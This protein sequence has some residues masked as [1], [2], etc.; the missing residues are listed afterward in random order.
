METTIECLCGA[1]KMKLT[2]EPIACVYCHCDDCQLVHGA[3]YLPAAM[4]RTAQTSLIAGDPILWKL[5]TTARATC[6]ACG[7]RVFAEPPGLGVRSITACLLPKGAFQPAFH[8]Q[9]QHALLPVRDALPH[10]KDYPAIFGGSD[11]LMPW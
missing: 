6:R 1:V 3:A 5:K 2:G 11:E 4:Y 7:T 10:Y 8:M 9:C